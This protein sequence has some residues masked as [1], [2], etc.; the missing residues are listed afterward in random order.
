MARD[1]PEA[2]EALRDA[3]YAEE[4]DEHPEDH[5]E[6]SLDYSS[7][8]SSSDPSSD[9]LDSSSDSSPLL[10]P[11]PP[12]D[13]SSDS[14]S[15]SSSSDS[16]SS[17]S[18]SSDSSFASARVSYPRS[19]V[20]RW[21]LGDD[22]RPHD[23]STAT[24]TASDVGA[25]PVR[26]ACVCSCPGVR[27]ESADARERCVD[28]DLGASPYYADGPSACE[29]IAAAGSDACPSVGVVQRC[30]PPDASSSTSS[31]KSS[32]TSSSSRKSPR[33][34]GRGVERRA[35]DARLG[36]L[37]ETLTR[38][39][40][41][42]P[43]GDRVASGAME[44][45]RRRRAPLP[46]GS[47][48]RAAAGVRRAVVPRRGVRVSRDVLRD[49]SMGARRR[50]PR[51]RDGRRFR[52]PSVAHANAN[53]NAVGS[54]PGI[55]GTPRTVRR[56]RGRRRR[57]SHSR[58]G[59]PL[60]VGRRVRR[61][62]SAR[63]ARVERRE[64]RDGSRRR[65][66]ANRRGGGGGVRGGGARRR[67]ARARGRVRGVASARSGVVRSRIRSGVG[68]SSA[69]RVT[70]TGSPPTR[71]RTVAYP[72]RRKRRKRRK[73]RGK[74]RRVA[75]ARNAREPP[76]RLAERPLERR[77]GWIGAGGTNAWGRS[78]RGRAR[79]R[80]SAFQA[81]SRDFFGTCTRTRT[82]RRTDERTDERTNE[83]TVVVY[84]YTGAYI[85]YRY[86]YPYP[87]TIPVTVKSKSHNHSRDEN[88]RDSERASE[89]RDPRRAGR[90]RRRR[91]RS[92][93]QPRDRARRRPGARSTP[94][95]ER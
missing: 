63:N 1:P 2:N 91:R 72:G 80:T 6:E 67:R 58:V 24:A 27:R 35:R 37:D 18:S 10:L 64:R 51:I 89:S 23:V 54:N 25:A 22:A 82:N 42:A 76:W 92:S 7:D 33:R 84:R 83:R 5:P 14:S 41:S 77:G 55:T 50:V 21:F 95:T 57:D 36:V 71:T 79:R 90:E 29:A 46:R 32:S 52:A 62:A 78:R 75:R 15:S 94:R 85:S 70:R 88:A 39:L 69:A 3:A 73:R 61:R 38:A 81:T 40:A 11:S 9:S 87:V 66:D 86:G 44:A 4:P 31:S 53:A 74:K 49:V 16:S 45:S 48:A 17:D 43:L 93:L 47:T 34:H 59:V 12:S 65:L 13:S 8:S 30:E 56:R 68:Y 26:G 19:G 60:R 28:V 20:P